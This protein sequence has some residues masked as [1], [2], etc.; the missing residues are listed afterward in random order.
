MSAVI[1]KCSY[2]PNGGKMGV[3]EAQ[4]PLQ[5]RKSLSENVRT[6]VRNAIGYTASS[7][8]AISIR[9][10]KITLSLLVNTD[11]G[12]KYYKF[13]TLKLDGNHWTSMKGRVLNED[14]HVTSQRVTQIITQ[15]SQVLGFANVQN[16]G[17]VEIV[18]QLRSDIEEDEIP[19][20]Q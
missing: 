11:M 6:I 18:G 2:D 14:S 7:Q 13:D 20:I 3:Y 19:N 9:P 1:Y 8:F 16:R 12:P 10:N 15:V 5:K 4:M 17:S